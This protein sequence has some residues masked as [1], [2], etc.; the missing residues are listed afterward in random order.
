MTLFTR[1]ILLV[2]IAFISLF[3]EADIE[4]QKLKSLSGDLERLERDIAKNSGVWIKSYNS[5]TAYQD[6]RKNLKDVE[7]RIKKLE[8]RADSEEKRL[9]L[10]SLFSKQKVLTEQ[11]ELSKAQGS[12]PFVSLLQPDEAGEVPTISNPFDI[13]SGLSYVKRLND[14]YKE[15]I[16]RENELRV[17]LTLLEQKIAILREM[18]EIDKTYKSELDISQLQLEKFKLAQ[19]T[20]TSTAG[21]YEKRIETTEAKI[22]KEIREQIFRLVNIVF[23]IVVLF[24]ISFIV[25]RILKRYI[26]DN[27]RFYIANKII[28]FVNVTLV[29]L[30]LL[31][32]YIDN[33]GYIATVLGVASA[34]LAIAMRDWFMSLLGWAVIMLGGSIHVG[35]RVRFVKD[36]ME[37]IGDVL[38][39]SMQRITMME[40]VTLTTVELNRRAGRII[41]VPNNYIFTSMIANYTHGSLKS[42]WDG[43]DI[44]ITFDSNV[45]KAAEIVKEV[46]RKHSKGYTEIARKQI[47]RMRGRYNLKSTN[48]EPRI[49]TLLE[50]YGMKI[51]GWYMVSAYSTLALRSNISVEIINAF[52]EHDDITIAYPTQTLFAQTSQQELKY[53]Q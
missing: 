21:V 28:T 52:K 43:V 37:Y 32:S 16:F 45:Q 10:D 14:Y 51:S 47:N 22:N 27:E 48:V 24:V 29:I 46:C 40:D 2:F 26:V 15:Y 35:D 44:V 34:G 20:L 19:E 50:P 33:V 9:E 53:N 38:D 39:I 18:I 13:F 23:I 36:G 11:I 4:S 25:K 17:V 1:A 41:F 31:F 3:A 49:F 12:S 30:I 5:Y 7:S 8:F 42:V 6:A